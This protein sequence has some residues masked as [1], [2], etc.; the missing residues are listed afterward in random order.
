MT[1]RTRAVAIAVVTL[2]LV[3]AGCDSSSGSGP[4]GSGSTTTAT[5]GAGRL[6]QTVAQV[7]CRAT[8]ARSSPGTLQSDQLKETSGLV[9]SAKNPG[10]L[11]LNNDSGDSARVF[12]AAPSGALQGIYPLDGATAID[13]EDI[14]IGPGPEADVPYLYVGDIGD[15]AMARANIVVYRVAEPKVTA[16]GGTHSLGNV[17]ALTLKYP[18]GPHDAEAL[19]VD[20]RT[21]ELYIVIKHLNGGNAAVY[22]APKNLAAGS[23]TTLTKV[24][25]VALPSIPFTAAVTAADISRDGTTIGIRTYGGVRLW[26][27]GRKQSVIDALAA[28]PCQGP[29]PVELQG[30]ALGF[31]SDARGYFTVSEGANVPI[32]QFTTR[33]S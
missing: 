14:A 31:Q 11:W 3:L 26:R 15:N 7:A 2:A 30:E 8:L 28:T 29:I 24:G 4:A 16:D 6:G 32:H 27:L 1:R 21:G 5:A 18:D 33:R 10:T 9:V 19:M 13:W 22:R 23:T 17:A 20:P 25:D 12:A